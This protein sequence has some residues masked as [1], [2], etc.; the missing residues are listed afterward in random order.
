M[1]KVKQKQKIKRR[2][3]KFS[4]EAV[5]VKEVLLMGDFNRLLAIL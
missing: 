1:S 2:K 5:D 3:V 4:L